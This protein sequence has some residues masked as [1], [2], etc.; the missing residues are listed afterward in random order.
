[1]PLNLDN[2]KKMKTSNIIKDFRNNLLKRR[3]VKLVVDAEKNP[4]FANASKIF[5]DELKAKEELVVIKG[6][7]SKFGRKTFLIDGLIYDSVQDKE[8]IEPKKKEKKKAAEGAAAQAAQE[9]KK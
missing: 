6:I 9:A 2:L 3:E 1:M 4:G 8:K 7:K 5:A